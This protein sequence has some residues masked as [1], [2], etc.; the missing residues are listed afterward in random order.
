MSGWLL[1]L[2]LQAAPVP[3]APAPAPPPQSA[4][5]QRFSILVPI[6]EEPCVRQPSD[7]DVVVCSNPLPSQK[8][9]YPD[10][11]VPDGPTPSNPLKSGTG[12]LAAQATP[13]PISRNCVVG[14]GPPIMPIIK[15]LVGLAKDTF[16]KKPDK[17]GRVPIPLDD[18]DAPRGQL[19]P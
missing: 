10:E 14:V 3:P 2:A 9:P 6:A 12:A 8:L 4:P 1:I 15:G 18:N 19:E 11:V 16:G 7:S 5:P 13:C 17:T